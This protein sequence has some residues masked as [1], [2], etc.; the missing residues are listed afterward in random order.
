MTSNGVDARWLNVASKKI[1]ME[2]QYSQ[3]SIS[4]DAATRRLNPLTVPPPFCSLQNELSD[5]I[6]L[7]ERAVYGISSESDFKRRDMLLA[8]ERGT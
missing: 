5:A 1:D 8:E 3:F 2:T 7:Q 6:R 4:V